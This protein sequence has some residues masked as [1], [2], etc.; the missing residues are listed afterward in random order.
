MEAIS[1][2]VISWFFIYPSNTWLKIYAH[3]QFP[4]AFLFLPKSQA[5]FYASFRRHYLDFFAL[6]PLKNFSLPDGLLTHMWHALEIYNESTWKTSAH[7]MEIYKIALNTDV[8]LASFRSIS[9]LQLDEEK[10]LELELFQ[11]RSSWNPQDKKLI[12]R[13]G[14]R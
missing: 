2:Q 9:F 7:D 5:K 12:V 4:R 6:I 14:N 13:I 3:R 10:S 8:F 11:S 1:R